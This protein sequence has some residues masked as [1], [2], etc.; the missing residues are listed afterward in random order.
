MV[1]RGHTRKRAI[2]TYSVAV[3]LG[4]LSRFHTNAPGH[5]KQ[6]DSSEACQICDEVAVC[7]AETAQHVF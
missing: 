7:D 5:K 6:P 3:C 1:A 2:Q 4:E